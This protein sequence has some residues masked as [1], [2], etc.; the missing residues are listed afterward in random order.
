MTTNVPR[1]TVHRA[2]DAG[3]QPAMRIDAL[4]GARRRLPGPAC[5][6]LIGQVGDEAVRPR[7]LKTE[8]GA[9]VDIDDTPPGAY[10]CTCAC[11]FFTHVYTRI[12]TIQS[13]I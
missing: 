4:A 2:R 8:L 3:G 11:A 6:A 10:A 1:V 9:S 12:T 13:K 7:N 5:E